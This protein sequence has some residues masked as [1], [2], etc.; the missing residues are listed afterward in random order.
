MIAPRVFSAYYELPIA[1]ECCGVLIHLV[2][3]RDSS[4]GVNRRQLKLK[5]ALAAV[6]VLALCASLYVTTTRWTRGFRLSA[7]N[8]FG[9]LRVEEH[10]A[11]SIVFIEGNTAHTL[12]G[13]PRYRELINGTIEH[14]IQFL[15]AGRKRDTT[16]YYGPKSGGAL[17]L[18]AAGTQGP[19][20]VG[21]LGLGTGT[22]AAYGRPGD[23]Y[24]FYEINPLVVSLATSQFSFIRDSRANVGI[25]VGDGR[26]SLEREPTHQF[27][28]VAIDAFSSDA[29]PTHLLTREAFAW[30]LRHLSPAGIIAVHVSN[31]YLDLVPV[32]ISAAAYFNREALV[33]DSARDNS[34]AIYPATWVLVGDKRGSMSR[35]ERSVMAKTSHRDGSLWTDD[36][37][38]VIRAFRW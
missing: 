22:L 6:L 17:A 33:I 10:V 9:V 15:T 20:K 32:V 24:T 7:R 11:P 26:L 38:S 16:T 3:Q 2:L 8:F 25:V 35:L 12:D 31:K 27:D 36:Y 5:Y 34:R 30:Y 23:Q 28:V 13:D 19:I 21:V 37:S 4:T 14:G 1:L 18:Q 29:I